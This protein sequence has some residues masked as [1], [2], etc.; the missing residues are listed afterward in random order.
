[1][2]EEGRACASPG[3]MQIYASFDNVEEAQTGLSPEAKTD[4]QRGPIS[5]EG[6]VVARWQQL[7][8]LAKDL[9]DMGLL[10]PRK[11]ERY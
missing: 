10:L 6:C 1:M 3:A 4:R 5:L 11:R 2:A 8:H 9:K 7:Q